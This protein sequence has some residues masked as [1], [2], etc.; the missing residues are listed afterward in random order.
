MSDISDTQ[1]RPGG[2]WLCPGKHCCDLR[3]QTQETESTQRCSCSSFVYFIQSE[4]DRCKAGEGTMDC[5][6]RQLVETGFTFW[7]ETL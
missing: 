6:R 2:V 4:F 5:V 1:D 7:S 3:Y